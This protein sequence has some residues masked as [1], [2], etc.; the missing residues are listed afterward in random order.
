MEVDDKRTLKAIEHENYGHTAGSVFTWVEMIMQ[1][2]ANSAKHRFE[3]NSIFKY[4]HKSTPSQERIVLSNYLI[5]IPF[6]FAEKSL[7][8]NVL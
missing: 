3:R 8:F 5:R 2:T 6:M 1:V 4:L 7:C